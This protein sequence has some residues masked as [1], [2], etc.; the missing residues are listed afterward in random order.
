[1]STVIVKQ[2]YMRLQKPQVNEILASFKEASFSFDA[3]IREVAV[4][5]ALRTLLTTLFI[6]LH[7]IQYFVNAFKYI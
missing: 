3:P 4:T 1:M 5:K 2:W 7:V 6:Y